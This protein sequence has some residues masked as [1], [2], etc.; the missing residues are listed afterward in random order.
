MPGFNILKVSPGVNRI[1]GVA[2]HGPVGNFR[3]AAADGPTG[4]SIADICK[5]TRID[6]GYSR[7][8]TISKIKHRGCLF[9]CSASRLIVQFVCYRALAVFRTPP[10]SITPHPCLW[11]K[12]D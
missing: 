5:F 12:P 6:P 7:S 1:P 9:I 4:P 8:G 2:T 11:S 3:V 10:F